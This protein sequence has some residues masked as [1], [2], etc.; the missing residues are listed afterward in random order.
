MSQKSASE[1]TDDE[2]RA[3]AYPS[4]PSVSEMTDDE[5]RAISYPSKTLTPDL[6]SP[7]D[8][9]KDTQPKDEDYFDTAGYFFQK[10]ADVREQARQ[11]IPVTGPVSLLQ[12]GLAEVL[13]YYG[14]AV[15]GAADISSSLLY[16]VSP[17]GKIIQPPMERQTAERK[18]GRDIYA[19]LESFL[20]EFARPVGLV[21]GKVISDVAAASKAQKAVDTQPSITPVPDEAIAPEA[22]PEL[23]TANVAKEAEQV[24]EGGSLDIP[25]EALSI[26]REFDI[27]QPVNVT[28]VASIEIPDIKIETPKLTV[29]EKR[30]TKEVIGDA[31]KAGY[32]MLDEAGIDWVGRKSREGTSVKNQVLE[33]INSNALP[34]ESF[35]KIAQKYGIS[36]D[37]FMRQLDVDVDNWG[38]TGLAMQYGKKV[39]KLDF[40][41]PAELPKEPWASKLYDRVKSLERSFIAGL[42]SPIATAARNTTAQFPRLTMDAYVNAI[43]SS[44]AAAFGGK[45]VNYT[46][47]LALLTGVTTKRKDAKRLA[48]LLTSQYPSTKGQLYNR[49]SGDVIAYK[50]NLDNIASES[51]SLG[52]K[53]AEKTKDAAV[54]LGREAK[55]IAKTVVEA[56]ADVATLK[57]FKALGKITD[58]TLDTYAKSVDTLNFLNKASE[59]YFRNAYFYANIMEK[60]SKKG[61]KGDAL[62]DESSLRMLN[63]Q[64]IKDAISDAL[65]GTYSKDIDTSSLLPNVYKDITDGI[66]KVPFAN[67]AL[68]NPFPRFLYNS[69]DYFYKHSPAG[70]F[71]FATDYLADPKKLKS[72]FKDEAGRKQL[73][74]IIAGSS[75]GGAAYYAVANGVVAE[76]WW[77]LKDS[78]S[79]E[80]IDIRPFA[81][82]AQYFFVSKIIHDVQNDIPL[83]SRE[84]WEGISGIRLSPDTGVPLFDSIIKTFSG[85]DSEEKTKKAL[86]ILADKFTSGILTPLRN[87]N[88]FVN[89]DQTYKTV[90]STGDFWKDVRQQAKRNIPFLEQELKEMESPTRAAAPQKPST[91]RVPF[92]DIEFEPV[93]IFGV[94][95]GGPFISQL[96]GVRRI[97]P[98]NII[99][100]ELAKFKFT[101]REIYA[102]TGNASF[103][104]SVK[105]YMG[106]IV[107]S[108]GSLV[109]QSEGYK[110]LGN[111]AK[112]EYLRTEVLAPARELARDFAKVEMGEEYS[113]VKYGR[114]PMRQRRVIESVPNLKEAI[115]NLGG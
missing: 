75:I 15:G 67:F 74:K 9:G 88:D 69:L 21:S 5:L 18:L 95:V 58:K 17:V 111:A 86:R 46:S 59:Y 115:I 39:E 106:P 41:N 82:L 44:L 37:D 47:S 61:L 62:F 48:N 34:P 101:N 7:E 1:M 104:N 63:E 19:G 87:W 31:Y 16:D 30:F 66:G 6:P 92:T 52:K 78:K 8:F 102:N 22:V 60:L 14:G 77:R 110:K 100:K 24:I 56:G 35:L 112:A 89:Q 36:Y 108:Y 45:P 51:S 3:I 73:S 109:A 28:P 2:L 25:E 70:V 57:P 80:T 90:E 105:K 26:T 81:P 12:R 72:L 55:D 42:V 13:P 113:K 4:Q 54:G 27:S 76:D 98:K 79:D 107:E 114:R 97:E 91:I 71:T 65:Y 68:G 50:N 10:G 20:P 43:D 84:I 23:E 38:R 40:L 93:D 85:V 83:D 49:Y 11:N 29:Q 99:E 53:I 64:D 33:L 96:T 94:K 103:D 32:E